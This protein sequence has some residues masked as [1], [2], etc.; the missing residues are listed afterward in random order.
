MYVSQV[1]FDTQFHA[2]T[3]VSEHLPACVKALRSLSCMVA[4]T[5]TAMAACRSQ[6]SVLVGVCQAFVLYAVLSG[7]F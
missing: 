7:C 3:F 5:C 1:R 4:L 2:S 6:A